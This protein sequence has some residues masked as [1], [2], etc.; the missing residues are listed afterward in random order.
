M[1]T[2]LIQSQLSFSKKNLRLFNSQL[3]KTYLQHKKTIKASTTLTVCV[4]VCVIMVDLRGS[5]IIGFADR[6]RGPVQT[7]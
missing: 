7:L 3:T 5:Y 4:C 6:G 1:H 2:K